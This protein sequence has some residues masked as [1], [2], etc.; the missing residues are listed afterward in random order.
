MFALYC[1]NHDQL[2]SALAAFPAGVA[3][4]ATDSRPVFEDAISRAACIVLIIQQPA[5]LRSLGGRLG[6]RPLVFVTPAGAGLALRV[7]GVVVE[8]VVA[9]AQMQQELWPS[10]GRAY[11]RNLL[12]RTSTAFEE[13][14]HI[15]ATLRRALAR[16]CGGEDPVHS[17]AEL[18]R[19]ISC[20]RRTI[21][22]HWHR[23]FGYSPPC[24][25][26]DFVDWVF[27][28]RLVGRKRP[29]RGWTAVAVELG[30]H[31]QTVALMAK[32]L[33][34]MGLRELADAGPLRIAHRFQSEV[35]AFFPQKNV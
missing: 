8:E 10:V 24:R 5:E 21:W 20:D 3:L 6:V 16:V 1:P 11:T 19:R 9:L 17:V 7:E 33:V 15:P 27:L 14:E 28:L 29:D 30:A 35:L 32:R 18:A 26:E 23:M 25:L 22:Y 34:G 31:E 12:A 13:A 2:R 4:V